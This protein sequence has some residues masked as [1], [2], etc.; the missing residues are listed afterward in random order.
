M[1][2]MGK[3]FLLIYST[4]C[5]HMRASVSLTFFEIFILLIF[6]W[7]FIFLCQYLTFK[8]DASSDKSITNLFVKKCVL[9]IYKTEKKILSAR[10]Y[11]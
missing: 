11:F 1:G 3:N 10:G 9:N 6:D 2:S 4:Y 8:S 5:N 7:F